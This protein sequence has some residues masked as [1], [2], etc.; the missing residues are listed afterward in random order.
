[1]KTYV[2]TGATGN[3]GKPI[4]LGLLERGHK[5]RVITRNGEKAQDLKDKGAEVF[6]GN[7]LDQSFLNSAFS[8]AD[9]VRYCRWMPRRRIIR[10]CR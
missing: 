6:I 3:T 7:P 8:G 10:L 2:I 9:A 4:S 5:V 1:M